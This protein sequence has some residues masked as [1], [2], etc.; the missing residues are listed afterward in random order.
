MVE[1]LQQESP[2]CLNITTA[3]IKDTIGIKQRRKKPQIR[4]HGL[5]DLNLLHDLSMR[6]N[7]HYRL[8]AESGGIIN[9]TFR[10]QLRCMVKLEF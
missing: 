1:T 2:G 3:S 4:E 6:L 10:R 7:T 9:G 8:A 5:S